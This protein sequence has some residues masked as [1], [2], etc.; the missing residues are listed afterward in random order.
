MDYKDLKT[1][2]EAL[3]ADAKYEVSMLSNVSAV[4]FQELEDINWVGFYYLNDK[5]L[6]LGPFQGKVACSILPYGKGVCWKAVLDKKTIVVDNV[7][8]F[9]THIACDADSNSEIVIPILKD[10]EIY[11]L[12]DIDSPK[13]NRFKEDDKCGLE[14]IALLINKCL[15]K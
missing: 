2:I 14:E 12:L 1:V 3:I 13:L 6:F 4:L 8:E 9:E 15:D 11:L 5:E 7:H 10:G